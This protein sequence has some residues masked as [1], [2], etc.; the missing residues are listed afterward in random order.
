MGRSRRRPVPGS[1]VTQVAAAGVAERPEELPESPDP[2]EDVLVDVLVDPAEEDPAE[3][4][5]EP[6][7]APD[8]PDSAEAPEVLPAVEPVLAVDVEAE[9]VE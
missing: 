1:G 6:P 8:P 5:E 2:L 3:L 4:S 9:S 7:D